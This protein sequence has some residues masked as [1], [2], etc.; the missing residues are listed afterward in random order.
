MKQIAILYGYAFNSLEGIN[1]DHDRI[2]KLMPYGA[3]LVTGYSTS[4][5]EPEAFVIG[6]DSGQG[7]DMFDP[8]PI[9]MSAILMG[10]SLD[11]VAAMD[12]WVIP[13]ELRDCGLI[14]ETAKLL[15][16]AHDDD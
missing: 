3:K 14:N 11:K 12:S 16:F 1:W 7:A 8:T 6:V 4:C 9:D 13:Q 10:L 2:A 15:L 5:Y